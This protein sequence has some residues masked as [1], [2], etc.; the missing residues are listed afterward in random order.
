MPASWAMMETLKGPRDAVEVFHHGR[1]A[2]A[3]AQAQ[4]AQAEHLAEGAGHD[5]VVAGI[6]QGGA[7]VVVGAVDVFGVGGVEHQQDVRRQMLAQARG[8]A[9]GDE[10]AGR[11]VGVGE[12]EPWRWRASPRPG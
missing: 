3:P 1:R 7:G 10:G 11:I 5:G 4:A 6:D 2:V 9:G 12:E 8:F